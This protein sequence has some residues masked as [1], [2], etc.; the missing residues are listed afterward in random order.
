MITAIVKF[1]VADDL[2][3]DEILD[4]MAKATQRFQN[5]PGLIR[6][7][8]LLDKKNG[9]GGGVYTWD[10]RKSAEKLYVEGGAW[11]EYIRKAYGAEPEITWYET[12]FIIDNANNSKKNLS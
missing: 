5:L 1:K 9:I 12:P 3:Q 10:S 8:F 11:R 6:K 4:G 2:S 7:N